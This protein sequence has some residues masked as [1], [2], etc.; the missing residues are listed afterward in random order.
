MKLIKKTVVNI[1]WVILFF[2]VVCWVVFAAQSYLT[3]DPAWQA[4]AYKEWDASTFYRSFEN[5]TPHKIYVPY[6]DVNDKFENWF[7]EASPVTI[8]SVGNVAKYHYGC[9]I[10]HYL[11]EQKDCVH[12]GRGNYSVDINN[13]KLA[14]IIPANSVAF[15]DWDGEEKWCAW[16]CDEDYW[17]D[18]TASDFKSWGGCDFVGEGYYSPERNNWINECTNWPWSS[19][20]ID[21]WSYHFEYTDS[22]AGINSCLW[23]CDYNYIAANNGKCY[24]LSDYWGS[25]LWYYS[26][27]RNNYKEPCTNGPWEAT[28]TNQSSYNFKYIGYWRSPNNTCSWACDENYYKVWWSCNFVGNG[29]YSD[30]KSN[31]RV[32]CNN[33]LPTNASWTSAWTYLWEVWG[34]DMINCDWA[35][36]DWY[37]QEG[38]NLCVENVVTLESRCEAPSWRS[39]CRRAELSETTYILEKVTYFKLLH[40]NRNR[41]LWLTRKYRLETLGWIDSWSRHWFKK[42]NGSIHECTT[43]YLHDLDNWKAEG[44][45][46][47]CDLRYPFD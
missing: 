40:S 5:L 8:R 23:A 43:S 26:L 16:R 47:T 9:K 31:V 18:D 41:I 7:E 4:W 25:Y 10:D 13:T 24:N 22:G 44:D 30:D 12:V 15:S 39:K 14:C 37:T 1:L 34:G 28:P 20:K 3:L 35:C 17:S 21:Q 6:T 46:S 2:S 32:S 33:T 27:H 42:P 11:N 38:S 45:R 19:N 29:Y 36:N